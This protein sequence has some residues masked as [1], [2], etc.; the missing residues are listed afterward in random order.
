MSRDEYEHKALPLIIKIAGRIRQDLKC[1]TKKV[2]IL[3]GTIPHED[4]NSYNL[5]FL[6]DIPNKECDNS[7]IERIEDD[8]SNI[9]N[10]TE[11]LRLIDLKGCYEK[12]RS[13]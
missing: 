11:W 2:E 8:F 3:A 6:T 5:V 7:K 10:P 13:D 12:F 1:E 9:T 4:K